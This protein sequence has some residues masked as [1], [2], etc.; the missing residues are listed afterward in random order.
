MRHNSAPVLAIHALLL[1]AFWLI[2]SGMFDPFHI[3]LGIISV[4]LTLWIHH[5]LL[6]LG[7]FEKDDVN[8]PRL[9]LI[10]LIP[11]F[12]FLFWSIIQSS[13][14]V[15]YLIA[16]PS[17]TPMSVVFTFKV[18]LPSM[19]ARVLLANSIT[20]T[21]GTVTLDILNED[22]FVVHAL[23]H[24]NDPVEMDHSLAHAVARLY[25]IKPEQVIEETTVISVD[26]HRKSWIYS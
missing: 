10:R 24:P 15:A 9:R 20:L 8:G 5:R 21:P 4:A 18:H 3:A 12:A 22:T 1:M 14:K 16:K 13:L 26:D 6:C 11:Y 25:G 19:G 7:Q 17:M 2:M 23:M